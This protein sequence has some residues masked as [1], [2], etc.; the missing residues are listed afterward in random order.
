M[1]TLIKLLFTSAIVVQLSSCEKCDDPCD[2]RC[3]N[4]DPC[5]GLAPLTAEFKYFEDYQFHPMLEAAGLTK[6]LIEADTVLDV[7]PI[8]FRANI[9]DADE[10]IWK[11]GDDD[12]EWNTREFRLSF[13]NVPSFT[14][15]PITLTVRRKAGKKCSF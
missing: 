13:S 11:V 8:L 3:D 1:K 9:E 10:Y 2:K 14:S 4:Y 6:K 7:S 12:R 15:I 5:C